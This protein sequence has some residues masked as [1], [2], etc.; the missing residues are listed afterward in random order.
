MTR[1][2][3][4]PTILHTILPHLQMN[5]IPSRTSVPAVRWRHL[6]SLILVLLMGLCGPLPAQSFPH[7]LSLRVSDGLEAFQNAPGIDPCVVLIDSGYIG[8]YP[9]TCTP[10]SLPQLPGQRLFRVRLETPHKYLLDNGGAVIMSCKNAKDLPP[11]GMLVE[12]PAEELAQCKDRPLLA[13][14]TVR[15][16][17]FGSPGYA[18]LP[19]LAITLRDSLRPS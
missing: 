10:D 13:I 17:V 19:M 16:H 8:I 1:L 5:A 12:H 15:P 4:S 9:M 11:D 18:K 7:T 6:P 2:P 14:G 3:A